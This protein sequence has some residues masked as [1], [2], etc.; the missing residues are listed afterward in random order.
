MAI[1]WQATAGDW[2][3]PLA[4]VVADDKGEVS[5]S[6]VVSATLVVSKTRGAPIVVGVATPDPDQTAHKGRVSYTFAEGD[7]D[8]AG[9]Y[10]AVFVIDWVDAQLTF[11]TVPLNL[12]IHKALPPESVLDGGMP[13]LTGDVIDGGTV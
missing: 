11:P 8:A 3:M 7:L 2:G 6:G 5:L 1:D 10:E 13:D 4:V 12:R 9:D